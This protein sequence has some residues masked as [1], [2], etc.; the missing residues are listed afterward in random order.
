MLSP[1]A[2]SIVMGVYNGSA[3]LPET[4]NSVLR[5]TLQDFELIVVNDGSTDPA[6]ARLLADYVKQ[7]GRVSVIRKQKEGL[8]RA[9]I[10]GCSAA[11]G[12]FIARIDAGDAM[13][14]ERLEK[15]KTLLDAHPEAVLATCWTEFCGPEW[16]P[17]YTVRNPEAGEG[18]PGDWV[19]SFSE[20]GD[21]RN[22]RFGP[23]HHG[24]VMFRTA[25]YRAAGGYRSR[26]YCGQDWDLWYR[27]AER[28]KFSGIQDV[29]YRCRIFPDGI[30][31]L[32]VKRQRQFHACSRGAFL[33]RARG[34]DETRFLDEA[35][36]IGPHTGTPKPAAGYYFIGEALR[37]NGDLRCRRYF[38]RAVECSPLMLKSGV[39]LIQSLLIRR[40]RPD[41]SAE[42]G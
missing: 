34:E 27:L 36:R 29:L 39:R 13:T 10:D 3:H 30:S 14:P 17:L 23:T 20:E 24:S 35:G 4:I 41:R 1:P 31:M 6:V 40:P 32:N 42:G 7:D 38:I 12:R 22:R 33:A 37:R 18:T 5:Q 26:F 21:D 8:T 11:R 28:G 25:D 16:E 15:Q 9:L 2:V 19:A